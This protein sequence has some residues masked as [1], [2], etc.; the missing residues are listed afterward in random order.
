MFDFGILGWLGF[1]GGLSAVA[2]GAAAY[3]LGAKFVV[4]ALSPILKSVATIAADVLSQAWVALKGL[5][6]TVSDFF[7]VIMIVAF[8]YLFTAAHYRLEIKDIKFTHAQ[9]L[10]KCQ[11]SDEP[12]SGGNGWFPFLNW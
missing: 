6:D 4:E 8:V 7:G 10:S 9:Q 11:S 1:S 5:F 2:L 12:A 3:F